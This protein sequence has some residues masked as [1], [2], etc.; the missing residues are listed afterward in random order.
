[1]ATAQQ[2]GLHVVRAIARNRSVIVPILILAVI[3]AIVLPLPPAVM[4]VLISVNL[5]LSVLIILISMYIDSPVD[6]SVFP[7]MILIMTLYRLALNIASTRLI[8]SNAGTMGTAAAGTVIGSFGTL[9]I[10]GNYV[11]GAVIFLLIIAIQYIVISQ[12]SVRIGEVS[13]RF[14][15]DA[16]PGKQMAIDADLNAGFI[17]EREARARRELIAQ[18]ASFY[19]AMDGAVRFTRRDAIASLI[20]TLVN[21]I[22]GLIIGTTSFG[23]DLGEA[24]TVFTTLTIGDGLVSALPSLVIAVAAGLV[25]TRSSSKESL[26]DE[27]V[28]QFYFDYRPLAIGA[29]MLTLFAV[30]LPDT[31]LVFLVIGSGL[32][33]LAYQKYTSVKRMEAA[34]AAAEVEKAKKAPSP[35]RVESLLQVDPLGLEVGY[36][37][38]PL[39]DV[40]QGGNIL[41]RIK[42]IRRQI[43]LEM[44]IVVPPIRIRDNLQL[45]PNEYTILLRGVVIARG[46]LM[47]GHFLAMSPGRVE[48]QIEGVKT[49]DPA[50]GLPAIWIPE[51]DKERA[52]ISGYTVVDTPTVISTH[53]TETIKNIAHKLLG[54]QE[55]Q[56]LIDLVAESAPKLVEE[57]V[58]KMLPL[59]GVQKILQNLLRERVSIRDLHTILEAAADYA[60]VT[61]DYAQLTEFVRV[62]LGRS[63]VQPYIN[64]KNELAILTLNPEL[65]SS[66]ADAIVKKETG[67]YLAMEPHAAQQFLEKLRRGIETSA[68]PVQPILLTS[69]EV[70]LHI[71]RLTERF[72]PGLVLISH[73][74]IPPQI[75]IINLGVVG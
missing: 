21:I 40:N 11:I 54:R 72:L 74:E 61:S 68:F 66:I 23:M 7:S 38:I 58:P 52:Q 3:G 33:F 53:L 12:G 62:S 15:L 34:T 5:T 30:F 10:A 70:R 19:G 31:R 55:V 8:L 42:S 24:A 69:G 9:V 37:L 25:V 41:D 43:A 22:G 16:M 51:T 45:E 14:T 67:A 17:D 2:T 57:T 50:F 75:S 27:L 59:G 26:G 18:E 13:A 35:E 4:D 47:M 56:A 20:I 36:N 32:A 71:R 6:F 73:G 65:E 39:V 64:D 60:A 49:T 44:G 48:S 1:V 46:Q 29:G 28:G 63:I